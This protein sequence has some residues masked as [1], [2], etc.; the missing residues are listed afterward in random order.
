ME[1]TECPSPYYSKVCLSSCIQHLRDFVPEAWISCSGLQKT[2]KVTERPVCNQDMLPI[3]LM[4]FGACAAKVYFDWFFDF[5]YFLSC[6]PFQRWVSLSLAISIYELHP[7]KK[8]G[9]PLTSKWV[10]LSATR[11]KSGKQVSAML[12]PDPDEARR[13]H[14]SRVVTVSALLA[15]CALGTIRDIMGWSY[16]ANHLSSG[17]HCAV[18]GNRCYSAHLPKSARFGQR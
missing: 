17:V 9:A 16:R 15:H 12:L 14:K 11:T 18:S 13:C 3:F 6:N 5:M 4:S 10:P 7:A 2:A 8:K 1:L